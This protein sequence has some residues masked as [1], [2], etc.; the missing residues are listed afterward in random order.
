MVFNYVKLIRCITEEMQIFGSSKINLSSLQDKKT[1][2]IEQIERITILEDA[3]SA[4]QRSNKEE[5]PKELERTVKLVQKLYGEKLIEEVRKEE[6]VKRKN[7]ILCK[8]FQNDL[9]CE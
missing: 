8:N 6:N 3:L 1:P 7:G 9:S 5:F 2:K 4:L